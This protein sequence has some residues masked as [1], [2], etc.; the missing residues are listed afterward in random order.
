MAVS[1]LASRVE[2]DSTPRTKG[3]L[4]GSSSPDPWLL[5]VTER[6]IA[7][8]PWTRECAIQEIQTHLE[9]LRIQAAECEMIRDLAT[10]PNKRELFDRLARHFRT[11]AQ[12]LELALSQPSRFPSDTFLGRKTHERFPNAQGE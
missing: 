10:T 9:K 7:L 12:E 8:P 2:F 1:N 4:L 3:N 11:L 5:P 6:P